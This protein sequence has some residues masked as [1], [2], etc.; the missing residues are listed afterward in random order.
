MSWAFV[1]ELSR[2]AYRWMEKQTAQ[3]LGKP[4]NG[5][6]PVWAWHSC[7]SWQSPPS[8]DDFIALFGTEPQP[9]LQLQVGTLEVDEDDFTLS[10]YGPWCDMLET[11]PFDP[12]ID[13]TER[14][15]F[16]GVLEKDHWPDGGNVRDLQAVLL[17]L[18]RD[19]VVSVKSTAETFGAW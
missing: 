19:Q 5:Q 6:P 15:W 4:S 13:A 7:G 8:H 11:Q 2:P 18:K 10:Y 17:V 1:N 14:L 16:D 3:R 12:E 9:H